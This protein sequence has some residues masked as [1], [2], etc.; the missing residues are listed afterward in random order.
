VKPDEAARLPEPDWSPP[1]L[2][3]GFP[4]WKRFA[5][6]GWDVEIPVDWDLGALEVSPKGGYFRLDDEFE[7]R[8]MVKWQP[9]GGR[10][11]PEKAI[12]RYFKKQPR[13]GE[14]R[15]R[16]GASVPGISKTFKG[17]EYETYTVASVSSPTR[18]SWGV[19]AH[20]P[21]C[22]RAF[23][24]EMGTDSRSGDSERLVSRVLGSLRDHSAD[25]L[26]RWEAYGLSLDL[27]GE[28]RA[29]GSRFHQGFVSLTASARGQRVEVCRWTLAAVHLAGRDLRSFLNTY[30]AKARNLPR[31]KIEPAAV[32]SHPG[33]T[34]HSPRR[35]FEP[36]RA[37][38]RQTLALYNPAHVTGLIWHCADTNRIFMLTLGSNQPND[39]GA[40]R[41][42][43]SRVRCCKVVY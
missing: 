36:A 26:T 9:L 38:V 37:R 29:A 8:L 32:M 12:A 6:D 15:P 20:C 11:D 28:L 3:P 13:T 21:K 41:L 5:W 24:V 31:L 16:L 39:M 10:F 7:P 42:L 19:S 30:L 35:L 33:C 34:F 40:A 43:A 1:P 18:S 27:P 14:L 4:R 17:L 2:P 23:V 25:K 22:Q